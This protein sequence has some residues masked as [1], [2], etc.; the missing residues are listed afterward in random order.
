M[1]NVQ[2]KEQAS[3]EPLRLW[4]G[5]VIVLLQWV[6]WFGAA[7]L[8]PDFIAYGVL[9]GVAAGLALIVWWLFFSRAGWYE[10]LGVLALMIVAMAA[11]WPFL[12]V[13]I[14]TGA[15]GFLFPMLAMPGLCLA[16][17][18]WAAAS[19][20]MSVGLQRATLVAAIVLPC[21]VWTLIRTGGF[22]GNF[23]NDL[24][25][26]WTATPEQRLLAQGDE[27]FDSASGKPVES[28][29]GEVTIPASTLAAPATH[30]GPT[31]PAGKPFD[32]GAGQPL[33]FARD[34][35]A[36][37]ALDWPGFR[38][39]D[40]DGVVRG[41][42]INTDWAGSPPIELW[43]RSIGP[44]WSSFA[45]HGDFLYTQE[46]RGDDEIV[47]A[48]RVSTGV[49]VWKHRD[50]ARFWESNGG[51]G[52]RA[53]PTF[54]GG[55]LYAF[56]A[57]GILNVL[58]AADG[59]VLWSRNVGADSNTKVPDWGFASSPLLVGDLVIVA[60]AGKLVAY[61]AATGDLRWLGPDGGAGYSSPHFLT[62]HGV[63]QI[64]LLD[65]HGATSVAPADGAR[66][67]DLMVTSSAMS[68]PIVQPA[69]TPDGDVLIGDG[70]ASGLSRIA[71]S[72]EAGGWTV[73][74]RW[75]STALKP[76]FNDFVVHKGHAFGFDGSILACIDLADGKRKWKGGRYGNGQ[77]ILLAD[78]DLL[79]VVSEEG[80]VAVV[81][82]A[83]DK[84]TQLARIPAI[85]GKTWNHPVL[86]GNVLLVRN[87]EEMAAF[88][89]SLVAR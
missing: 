78:Q 13:S 25:W 37:A 27:F 63:P 67:W 26:R 56:G 28:V 65:A 48:Y 59:R 45:V 33:G 83:T 51:A 68:S 64:L 52:P 44:G 69:L 14:S 16:F 82:A 21:G 7:I 85:E 50:A 84:F 24:A 87:G 66:L 38:G 62:I 43:R 19:R 8:S 29:R 49:P 89:L 57:T 71:V 6:A 61:E 5:V 40:R 36:T 70:Q 2:V 39:R 32:A 3:Q 1:R 20:R 77:L 60:A 15:M 88:R 86:A 12:D 9:A 22:T 53:T 46:Q 47:A 18:L 31:A 72:Q 54:S 17:V 11:T 58:D 74:E 35:P 75:K 55:R 41:V 34:E 81:S 23:D 73:A 76:F 42:R 30:E 10:R 80:E 4:P 79:L